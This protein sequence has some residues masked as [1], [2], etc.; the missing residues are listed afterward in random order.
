[1]NQTPHHRRHFLR[2]GSRIAATLALPALAGQ[3]RAALAP[4]R[5][6]ALK[7]LHTQESL[8]LVYARA[9]SYLPPALQSLDRLLR[10]HHSGEVGR[11]DPLLFDLL[12][13]LRQRLAWSGGYEVI[14][15]YRAPATNQHLKATRGGGVARQSLHMVGKAIDVRLPGVA[16]ADL[17]DAALSL[18]LG[19][20]GYYPR[21]NFVHVDTGRV[22]AW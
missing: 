2:Q 9:S 5:S 16:L 21:E 6:L 10:D 3:A 22:R 15:G 13:R 12:H 17:R 14:S 7:H 20:V 1:M 8:D 19:G 11:M 18:Q 4:E